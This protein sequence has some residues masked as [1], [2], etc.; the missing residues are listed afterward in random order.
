M[1]GSMSWWLLE[2]VSW[3][4]TPTPSL[5]SF[6]PLE[7]SAIMSTTMLTV[8]GYLDTISITA[9]SLLQQRH[10]SSLNTCLVSLC[11]DDFL[12]S[13]A[14]VSFKIPSS[15][16][17]DTFVFIFC[18]DNNLITPDSPP[19][20]A[21]WV[22]TW[23]LVMQTCK[24]WSRAVSDRSGCCKHFPSWLPMIK[25]RQFS[26]SWRT[27]ITRV[28]TYPLSLVWRVALI[29]LSQMLSTQSRCWRSSI[30]NVEFR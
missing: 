2:E 18:C 25:L 12:S 8:S 29:I 17:D 3:A 1:M 23:K 6:S 19:C 30:L 5:L 26:N 10:P 22:E 15:Q 4:K 21:T 20:L 14:N 13:E 27:F 7:T 11:F 16:A 28:L 24:T 9:A